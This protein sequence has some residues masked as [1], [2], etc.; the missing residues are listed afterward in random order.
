MPYFAKKNGVMFSN[1]NSNGH[2]ICN[3][4]SDNIPIVLSTGNIKLNQWKE[5]LTF[6]FEDEILNLKLP[7]ALLKNVPASFSSE[8][9]LRHS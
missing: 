7:P 2:G 3:F 6:I 9:A 5:D 8:K 1:I 4:V